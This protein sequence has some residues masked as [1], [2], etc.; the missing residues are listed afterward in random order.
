MIAQPVEDFVEPVVEITR[1]EESEV[2]TFGVL[3]L[4]KRLLCFTLEPPDRENRK[5]VSSIPP[6]QYRCSRFRSR[7]FGETFEVGDVPGRSA[8]LFHAGNVVGE[9]QGCFL[10]G[11]HI[12][13]LRGNRA[14]LA[15]GQAFKAF[16]AS[17]DGYDSF[18]LTVGE[19]Y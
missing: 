17:L 4:N 7:K 13:T 3:R 10:L 5:N 18:H 6:Q 2:G 19:N 8:I 16:M 12:G 1:L 15:S 11:T 9:T 14:I